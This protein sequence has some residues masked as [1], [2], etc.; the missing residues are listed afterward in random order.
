M[1]SSGQFWGWCPRS[2]NSG[3]ATAPGDVSETP[4]LPVLGLVPLWW[5]TGS[6]S[7]YSVDPPLAYRAS[8][9]RQRNPGMETKVGMGG[10]CGQRSTCPPRRALR[11]LPYS[12]AVSLFCGVAT[13]TSKTSL[14][15]P[16]DFEADA[17]R[18][19]HLPVA[20]GTPVLSRHCH[21]LWGAALENVAPVDIT[22]SD[23]P[24]LS[25]HTDRR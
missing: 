16:A 12:L 10:F 21:G 4:P 11:L 23:M 6:G 15:S 2:K 19:S 14:L 1:P 8:D 20:S 13:G 5:I 17:A 9:S 24:P 3:A 18:H 22:I 25:S 7:F